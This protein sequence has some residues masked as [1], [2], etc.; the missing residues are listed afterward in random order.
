MCAARDVRI[1]PYAEVAARSDPS[2]ALD[3]IFFEASATRSFADA[4]E[5]AMFRERWLGRYLAHF[6]GDAFLALS[7]DGTVVGYV[8]GSLDDPAGNPLFADIVYFE[9]F[10]HLTAL[11]PAHLHINIDAGYRSGGIGAGLIARFLA[12]ARAADVSGVHVVTGVNSRNV[13]F[14]NRQGFAECGRQVSDGTGIVFLARKLAAE[15]SR[16]I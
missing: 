15:P 11:Y 10:A 1:S 9:T 8:A 14:Y 3:A 7:D 16:D 13:S 6:P 4:D 12:H 2:A 5:R